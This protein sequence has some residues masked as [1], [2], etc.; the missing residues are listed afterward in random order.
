MAINIA[1]YHFAKRDNSTA[2]PVANSGNGTDTVY[3]GELK[4]GC[5]MLSPQV[6]FK[7]EPGFS[8]RKFNYGYIPL[9]ERYYFIEDW[10]WSAGL[11]IAK[12]GVDVLA[13]WKL[14]IEKDTEYI[15]RAAGASNGQVLDLLYPSKAIPQIVHSTALS[16]W[17]NNM[18]EGW[19]VLGVINKDGNALS[20]ISYYVL[21]ADAMKNFKSALLGTSAW[22]YEGI[23]EISEE[24]TR[25]LVNPYQYIASCMWFP[26]QPPTWYHT[27]GLQIGWW[28]LADVP[29][30]GVGKTPTKIFNGSISI[31]KHPQA[32]ARGAYLNSAPY[33]SYNIDFRPFGYINLDAQKLSTTSTLYWQYQL[34]FV[35]GGATLR[36]STKS[37]YTDSVLITSAQVGVPVQLAQ[38][39]TDW[40][41]AAQGGMQA[42]G[43]IAGAF[44]GDVAGGIASAATGIGN[45][46]NALAPKVTTSGST[47]SF[48]GISKSIEIVATFLLVVDEDNETRGRPLC[49]VR[50][51]G[52]LDG[53]IQVANCDINLP[54]TSAEIVRVKNYMEGGFF[55]EETSTPE[56]D[57]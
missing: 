36:L 17:V 27:S 19:F 31:P 53:Y 48:A 22:L 5:S 13:T 37:D 46:L 55:H 32:A 28:N 43:G 29:C 20:A 25:A 49:E 14:Y 47:G 35:N 7:F 57:T 3:T 52:D 12:M 56:F 21:T 44:L 30:D 24:L 54:A 26:V 51:V 1:L 11:W 40:I 4:T 2:R 6:M 15:T 8:P 16:G 39:A 41:G 18:S 34:D 50:R 42:V 10:E 45:A 23:T 9:F 33:S 38:I